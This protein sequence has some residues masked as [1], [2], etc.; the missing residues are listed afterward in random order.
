MKLRISGNSL[1]L[2]LNQAE[3]AQFS[4][5]GF[6]EDSVEFAHGASFCY[7]L[8]SLSDLSSPR[9]AYQNGWL[10]IQIPSG[11]ATEWATTDRVGVSGE[12]ALSGGKQLSIL[13][14]KDFQCLHGSEA[15]DPDAFPNPLESA[16]KS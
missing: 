1:R 4:K 8:E 3:V 14:E 16:A 7:A 15:P 12:Q 13:I 9:A 10:R 2:R 11:D 6:V 5:T